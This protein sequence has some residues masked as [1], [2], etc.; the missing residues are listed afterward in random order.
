MPLRCPCAVDSR[1]PAFPAAATWAM[2]VAGA[3]ACSRC[4]AEIAQGSRPQSQQCYAFYG[5]FEGA[6]VC[7]TCGHAWHDHG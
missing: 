7:Q 1:P 4:A 5:A 2:R 3:G 6:S